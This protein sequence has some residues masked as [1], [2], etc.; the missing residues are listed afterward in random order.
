VFLSPEGAEVQRLEGFRPPDAFLVEARKSVDSSAAMAKLKEAAEANPADTAAQRAY[1][2]SLFA[3]GD[4]DGAI[5][6]LNAALERA[7]G[8]GARA[9]LQ[10]DLGDA[11]LQAGKRSEARAAYEKSAA[12]APPE[13][14]VEREKASLS[15]A[16]VCVG[17]KDYDAALH[18]LGGLIDKGSLKGKERLEALFLRGYTYAVKKDAEKALA[19]LRVA[20]DEDKDGRWGT[21]AGLIIDLVEAK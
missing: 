8:D 20:R 11:L 4:R 5:K 15:F 3:A 13:L 6:V 18:A 1:A 16:R 19:D 17:L 14:S 9:G 12:L 2:R 21:R 7:D 10:L